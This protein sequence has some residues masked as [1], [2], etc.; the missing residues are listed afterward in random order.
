[1]HESMHQNWNVEDSIREM[2]TGI[3]STDYVRDNE[4]AREGDCTKLARQTHGET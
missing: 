3:K 4:K 2:D 1:M